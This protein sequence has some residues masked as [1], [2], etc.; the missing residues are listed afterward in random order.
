LIFS[1]LA[2]STAFAR[3]TME[4]HRISNGASH[5]AIGTIAL[6][7]PGNEVGAYGRQT[8]S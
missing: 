7:A 4:V 6:Q 5:Q 8:L 1:A 2:I 3:I